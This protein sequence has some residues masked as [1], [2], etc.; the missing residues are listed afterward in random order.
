MILL[1]FRHGKKARGPAG[2]QAA[3]S[4]FARPAAPP[5]GAVAHDG[6]PAEA[7]AAAS[8]AEF[9]FLNE[10]KK[11]EYHQPLETPRPNPRPHSRE[12]PASPAA[13]VKALDI[14]EARYLAAHENNDHS[15]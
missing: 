4:A 1:G 11:T 3:N 10:K 7:L 14:S 15:R 2:R 8:E 6:T 13:I 5:F 9:D 12:F